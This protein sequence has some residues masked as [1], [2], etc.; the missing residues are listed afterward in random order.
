M[1]LICKNE[2]IDENGNKI[3]QFTKGE[4]YYFNKIKDPSGW[5]VEDDNGNT[6]VFFDLDVMFKK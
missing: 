4:T 3:M 5:E 1:V 2:A 6:E